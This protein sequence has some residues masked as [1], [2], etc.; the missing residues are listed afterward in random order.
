MTV[1]YAKRAAD[2]VLSVVIPSVPTNDHSRT[3]THLHDQTFSAP[4]EIIIVDDATIDRS[5]ARNRGLTEAAANVVALTDD[6]TAPP[7]AWLATIHS[8]FTEAPDLVC[9]EGPVYGGCRNHAPR[10]YVGCN[11]AVRRDEALAIGGFRSE[12]SEWRKDVEVG[13]RMERD[14][15][16][17]CRYCP[18][19]RMRHPSVPRT[20]FKPHLE[21]RLRAEYPERYATVTVRQSLSNSR[22]P[23][24]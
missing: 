16:G 23:T 2:P 10:H 1:R 24:R 13:W 15:D 19:M 21:R 3:V 8:A 18:E 20:S 11:L 4:Y 6:D 5:V 17:D 9:L 7:P 22:R 14:A 12:F